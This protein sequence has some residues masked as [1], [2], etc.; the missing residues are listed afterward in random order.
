MLFSFSSGCHLFCSL[1]GAAVRHTLLVTH[2]P[3]GSLPFW[4]L[5]PSPCHCKTCFFASA[6]RPCLFFDPC[7]WLAGSL[8]WWRLSSVQIF[9]HKKS[10]WSCS[11]ARKK[12]QGSFRVWAASKGKFVVLTAYAGSLG[13]DRSCAVRFWIFFYPTDPRNT[14]RPNHGSCDKTVRVYKKLV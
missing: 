7:R 9:F 12:R 5:K 10:K 8:C 13:Y 2:S 3:G 14:D 4:F 6:C 1:C 11:W